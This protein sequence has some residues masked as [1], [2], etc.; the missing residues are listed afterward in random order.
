MEVS[1]ARKAVDKALKMLENLNSF[2]V[3]KKILS[4]TEKI[5]ENFEDLYKSLTRHQKKEMEERG[6]TFM[7]SAQI[8]KLHKEQGVDDPEVTTMLKEYDPLTAE[9]REEA[10]WRTIEE[11]AGKTRKRGKRQVTILRPLLL[12]PFLFAPVTGASALGPLLLSPNIFSPV[13]LAPGALA[14]W[15]LSPSLGYPVVL[16]PYV[17]SPFILSPVGLSVSVLSP[18]ALSPNI[19]DPSLLTPAIL[20]PFILSPSILSP[21]A[22]GGAVLSPNAFS[23]SIISPSFLVAMLNSSSFESE[24]HPQ[25]ASQLRMKLS[26]EQIV[27]ELNTQTNI[28]HI[29]IGLNRFKKDNLFLNN[30]I[31]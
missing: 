5:G 19:L 27:S 29:E 25:T 30:K 31:T 22:L 1:G 24:T 8:R 16:S 17:L 6:F 10:L 2:G 15:I 3:G 4:V 20:S 14:P 18:F 11:I 12:S 21:S 7:K 26:D 13:I 23:P 9:E 28:E